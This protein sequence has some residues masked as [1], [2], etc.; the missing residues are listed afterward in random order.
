MCQPLSAEEHSERDA[1]LLLTALTP[2]PTQDDVQ[3]RIGSVH[4]SPPVVGGR[5]LSDDDLMK[6]LN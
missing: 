1:D 3:C 5:V 4:A 6:L 2:L